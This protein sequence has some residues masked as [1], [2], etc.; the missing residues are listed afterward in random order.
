MIRVPGYSRFC[1]LVF[2][3]AVALGQGFV[4][5]VPATANDASQTYCG[6]L[7]DIKIEPCLINIDRGNGNESLKWNLSET[8][9]EDGK[10]QNIRWLTFLNA[11]KG[12]AV[13]VTVSMDGGVL[14]V[15]P[16]NF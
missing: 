8:K 10:R 5:P 6:S 11:Y 7:A 14:K 16:A 15:S 3:L 9:F 1:A 4:C 13:A 2:L 12:K